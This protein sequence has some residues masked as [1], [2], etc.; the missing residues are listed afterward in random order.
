[1]SLSDI[2]RRLAALEHLQLHG[3]SAP[4]PPPLSRV[5]ASLRSVSCVALARVRAD[6]YELPLSQRAALLRCNEGRLCKTLVFEIIAGAPRREDQSPMLSP[7]PLPLLGVILQYTTR[8]DLA[9]LERALR[10][11]WGCG[12]VRL[13]AAA[14]ATE[15]CGFPHNGF[16]PFGSLTRLQLVITSQIAALP[17]PRFVWVGGGEPDVKLRVPVSALL[18]ADGGEAL[19]LDV[20][21]ECG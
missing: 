4:L 9:A 12:E 14:D 21:V 7:P 2:D 19:V 6:Y 3:L 20:A 16:S 10:A 8:L 5:E 11:S 18:R 17:A 1:M 13:R 15:R